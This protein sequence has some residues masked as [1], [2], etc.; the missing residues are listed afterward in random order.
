MLAS[1]FE[2]LAPLERRFVEQLLAAS[3]E[4]AKA[5]NLALRFAAMV[6]T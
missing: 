1:G 2:K 3:P 4:I 6:R 5:R